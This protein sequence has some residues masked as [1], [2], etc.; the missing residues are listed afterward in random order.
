MNILILCAEM[1]LSEVYSYCWCVHSVLHT[2][3][4]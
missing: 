2:L 3:D 1:E 4:E